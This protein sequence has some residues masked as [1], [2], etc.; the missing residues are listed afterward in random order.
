MSHHK[1]YQHEELSNS[2]IFMYIKKE[3]FESISGGLGVFYNVLCIWM[4][5]WER[6]LEVKRLKRQVQL[7]HF[8]L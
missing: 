3:V 5:R 1:D 7:M 8:K 4:S 2:D 6:A